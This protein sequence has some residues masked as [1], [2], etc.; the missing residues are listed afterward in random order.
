MGGREKNEE[1]KDKVEEE[2]VRGREEGR[3]E[4]YNLLPTC[5]KDSATYNYDPLPMQDFASR[6]NKIIVI[7]FDRPIKLL[8]PVLMFVVYISEFFCLLTKG[9]S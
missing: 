1:K 8:I 9:I 5:L 2:G 4:N 6:I 7:M 3:G